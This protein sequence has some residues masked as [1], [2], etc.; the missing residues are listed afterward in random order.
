[1]VEQKGG[2]LGGMLSSTGLGPVLRL[3]PWIPAML[4]G[5]GIA[6][7]TLLAQVVWY[8]LTHGEDPVLHETLMVILIISM[9][10]GLVSAAAVKVLG[11]KGGRSK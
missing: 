8:G 1:M 10:A 3:M 5:A 6:V 9:V 11:G 7:L 2:M 4:I